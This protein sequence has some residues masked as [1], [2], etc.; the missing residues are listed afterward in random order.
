MYREFE[1]DFQNLVI[2]L[3]ER[4]ADCDAIT[5]FEFTCTASGRIRDG[6]VD[7]T[8]ELTPKWNSRGSAASGGSLSATIEEFMRRNDWN[9]AHAPLCLPRVV[10]P[11]I[12]SVG[13]PANNEIP[14]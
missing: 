9:K 7:L 3:R 6:D 11:P 4:L 13:S 5:E 1:R 10:E 12:E 8:F 14:F 2:D